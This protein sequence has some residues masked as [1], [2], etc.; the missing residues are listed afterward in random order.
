MN[1]LMSGVGTLAKV[2]SGRIGKWVV[3]GLWIVALAVL[4]PMAGSLSSVQ[5]NQMASWLP[6]DAESTKAMEITERFY[7]SNELPAIIVY[8]KTSGLTQADLAT[9]AGHVQRFAEVDR[10]DRDVLGPLPSQESPAPQAAQVFVPINAGE[11]GWQKLPDLVAEL[12]TIADVGDSGMSVHVAGPAGNGAD[13]AKAFEGIDGTLLY[14]ALIVV[15]VMLLITYR[16]PVLWLLPVI[17]A[18]AALFAAQGVIYLLAKYAGLTVNGQ[19]AGILTVL[20]FG[21]GTDYALL[22]V[23]RYREE[24]RRHQDRHEAMAFAL[25]RAGPA[26]WASAATVILGMIC[27]I[28]AALNSTAGL[29]PVAAI[30]VGVGV[31]AMVTLL[32]AL[33]VICGRWLFWPVRP[34]FGTVDHTETGVWAKIGAGIARRPRVVWLVTAL[35]LGAFALNTLTLK[36]DGIS[37]AGSFTGDVPDSVV[38]SQVLARHFPA[39]TEQPIQV[40]AKADKATEVRAAL[41]AV[42]GIA[43]G[44]V[45]EPQIKDGWALVQGTMTAAPD[46]P[47]GAATVD[48][49]REAVHRVPDAEAMA[50]GMAAILHDTNEANTRDRNLIIPIVLL[51]VFLILAGLLRALVAPLV[52]MATVVLSFFAALG[53]S[54]FF[55]NQVFGFEGADASFPLFVFVFLVSLGIDYNIF[56]MT[57]VHEEA[58]QW[59]TRRGALIGLSATGGVITSAGLVLAGTFAV[60]A[61][62]PLVAFA[63]IG[64]AVAVGVIIDTII[65]RGVLVTALTLD[66]G[67]W[68]W[69]PHRLSGKRD[70]EPEEITADGSSAVLSTEK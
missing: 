27:L 62:L 59:G 31:L 69:W 44:S 47:E 35:V 45:A 37:T 38:G 18:G 41:S 34:A 14:A 2:P 22:L 3:L 16:S 56:L 8:E 30:G 13:T 53:I 1:A 58:K 42:S 23:A 4:A 57:R 28:F 15:I 5:D 48:R 61:T 11:D 29:G 67:R 51:V 49:V 63:E 17:S 60:L 12:R 33:L 9:I 26:I 21:A 20:V 66:I 52:L 65:V 46:G 40:V 50:G 10:V 6:S 64:F 70:V 36:S 32:P 19:S 55:F 7:S 68:M 54:A 43:P 39:G 24:L 25:H